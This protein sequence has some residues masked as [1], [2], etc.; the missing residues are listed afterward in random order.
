MTSAHS[1]E[2]DTLYG[3]MAE[4]DTPDALTEAAEKAVAAGYKKM[5]AYSPFPIEEVIHAL[6]HERN[7]LPLRVLIG[8]ITGCLTGFC[9]QYYASV[10]DYPYVY[11][12]KPFNSWPAFLPVCF[13]LTILFAAFTA[14]FGMLAMNELP[15]PYHP[16]FNVARFAQFASRDKFFLCIESKDPLFDLSSTKSFLTSLKPAGIY[17]VEP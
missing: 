11:G 6:G 8:G 9:M 12:G 1:M 4:F 14:V 3:L 13:E 2:T 15:K 10:I 5:D 7:N 16:V 17:E